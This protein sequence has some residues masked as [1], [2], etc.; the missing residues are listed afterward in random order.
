MNLVEVENLNLFF[1]SKK[2]AVLKNFNFK[3]SP[4]EVHAIIGA[5]GSGKSSFAL[6]LLN[7]SPENSKI[8]FDKF[9]I[10]GKDRKSISNKEWKNIRGKNIILI[11]Q[12]PIHSF[13][14]YL[15]VGYQI[16]DYLK[17]KNIQK[18]K[19][20]IEETLNSFGIKNSSKKLEVKPS[21]LSG[22]ERQ[23]IIIAMC[24]FL[25]PEIILAD[26]PTT[27]LDSLNEKVTLEVLIKQVK[28][29]NSAL[30]LI[31]HDRRLVRELANTITVLKH[32]K[33]VETFSWKTRSKSDYS[34][35]YT[36]QLLDD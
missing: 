8:D 26:E 25:K 13:H 27:A 31:T 11:P 29:Q 6:N 2:E 16:F 4:G 30:I 28:N 1:P 34:N 3:I 23:R 32:G 18:S 17:L 9:Q 14:P 12:N 21:F 10:L 7:L 36:K 24:S 33:L 22:G 5:S 35:I 20:E 19:S 15:S